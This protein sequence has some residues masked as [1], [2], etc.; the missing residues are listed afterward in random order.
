MGFSCLVMFFDVVIYVNLSSL[1]I[2]LLRK[3]E[4]VVLYN[5]HFPLS[6]GYFYKQSGLRSG[7][8]QNIRLGYLLFDT[9]MVFLKDFLKKGY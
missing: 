8:T 9:L 1:A 3:R 6:A 5:L 4:L 7:A 2:F